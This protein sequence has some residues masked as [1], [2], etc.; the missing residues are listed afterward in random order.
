MDEQV[1]K[2]YN[3]LKSLNYVKDLPEDE[4]RA[5]AEQNVKKKEIDKEFLIGYKNKDELKIAR[6]LVYR[7]LTDYQLT[8]VSDRNNLKEVIRLEV[9]QNRLHD[10]LNEMYEKNNGSL[11]LQ[12]LEAIQKNN[13]AII[14]LKNTLGLNQAKDKKPYDAYQHLKKRAEKWLEENQMSRTCKCPH[15][16]KFIWMKMRVDAWEARKHPYFKDNVIYNKALFEKYYGKTVKVDAN[17]I[18]DVLEVSKDF[19]IWVMEKS[20]RGPSDDES[21]ETQADSDEGSKI[22]QTDS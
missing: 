15:C 10:K 14:K 4:I 13:D 8:S 3:R 18:A 6:G 16:Q 17:F 11:S 19:P 1:E 2:E 12:T 21:K 9:I 5:K 7:Y 20:R 22:V